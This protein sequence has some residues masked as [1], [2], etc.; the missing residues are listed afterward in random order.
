MAQIQ[1]I[2]NRRN[3]WR[4]LWLPLLFFSLLTILATWPLAAHLRTS[5]IGINAGDNWYYVWL[6]GWFQKALFQYHQNPLIVQFQNYPLGWNLA[7]SEITLVNVVAALPASLLSG[8]ILGYNFT[9]LLTFILSGLFMFWWVKSLTGSMAAGLVAG[10]A[11]AYTPY[12]MAHIYGHL[13]LMGTQ[14][15]VL[16]FAGLYYLL[17]QRS[18]SWK[19]AAM[20]GVGL[21]LAALSSMYYLYLTAIISIIFVLTYLLV[22]ERRALLR[23]AW[24][25]N[26]L[27]FAAIAAP[28]ILIAVFPYF[29]LNAQGS[30]NHRPLDQVDVFSASPPDFVIPSP[31]HFL[32]GNWVN[33]HFD[34]SLWIEQTLYIG[35]V[36]LLLAGFAIIWRKK[37]AET[38]KS[39]VL[40]TIVAGAAAILAMGTTLHWFQE[41]V[42]IHL[43]PFL[44]FLNLA[45]KLHIYLPNYLL[46]KYLPF[47]NSMRAWMRYGIYTN[48]F[49]TVIAGIG[50][51][52]IERL[53]KRRSISLL[54]LTFTLLLIG[55]DFYSGP[56]SLS[57][58]KPRPVD[59]WL[60]S[61]PGDGSYIQLPIYLNTSPPLVYGTLYNDKP[62][63]GMFYGAYLPETYEREIPILAGFPDQASVDLLRSKNGKY[64]LVEAAQYAN[65]N[66][67]RREI[68]ALGLIQTTR[69]YGQYVFEFNSP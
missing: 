46:Y 5:V 15:L 8:P 11:F 34:R 26:L 45:P 59:L 66:E 4:S 63:L 56:L 47:Y 67:T 33:T 38:W 64:I 51:A 2:Q 37:H 18:F 60:G 44:D 52:Q 50:F 58:V 21:G 7:Y 3:Y 16:H 24:W 40:F 1:Q 49:L 6:I 30:A 13:P 68:K 14:Y 12:R 54:F 42:T 27:A 23:A 22:I 65:W 41:Q 36:V 20:A 31:L 53:I 17:K 48:L 32:W 19:Y 25:R 43:P 28:L 39:I 9:I 57:E 10:T 69:T 55:I 62:F 29:Q 61:Q 35:I